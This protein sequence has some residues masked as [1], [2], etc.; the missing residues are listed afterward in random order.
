MYKHHFQSVPNIT[1]ILLEGDL[2]NTYS[3]SMKNFLLQSV[4]DYV[5]TVRTCYDSIY[6]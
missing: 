1:C 5:Q 2:F 3:N 4:D 6:D